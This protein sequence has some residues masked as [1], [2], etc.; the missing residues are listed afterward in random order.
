MSRM[1]KSQYM[2]LKINLQVTHNMRIIFLEG[3]HAQAKDSFMNGG[4]Y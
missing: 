2:D 3:M 1:P 4:D